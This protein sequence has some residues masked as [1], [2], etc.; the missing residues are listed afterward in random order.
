ML[1]FIGIP[2]GVGGR[3]NGEISDIPVMKAGITVRIVIFRPV[4]PRVWRLWPV[5]IFPVLK[6]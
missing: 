3:N 1:G 6:V 4:Y 2:L 5:L